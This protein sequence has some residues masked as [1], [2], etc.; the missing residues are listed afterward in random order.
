ML[1]EEPTPKSSRAPSPVV[2]ES[3]QE[4]V[5]CEPQAEA[6][7]EETEEAEKEGSDTET[8]TETTTAQD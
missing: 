4:S 7:N 8:M 2:K 5:K 3:T 6:P 1:T